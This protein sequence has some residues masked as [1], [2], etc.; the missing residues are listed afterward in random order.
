MKLLMLLSA[1]CILA[2]SYSQNFPA[3]EKVLSKEL[4]KESHKDGRWVFFPEQA[5]IQKLNAPLFKTIFPNYDLFQLV[6]TNYLGYHVNEGVCS[7]LFDSLTSQIILVEPIWYGGISEPL[8]KLFIGKK[9]ANKDSLLAGL[10]AMHQVLQIGSGYK[11][12][13]TSVSDSLVTYDLGYFKGDAYT[14]G[15]NGASTTIRYNEDGVWR[16]IRIEIDR[17]KI[18]RYTSINPKINE[19]EIIE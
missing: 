7:V 12:R 9:F 6:L 11:F 13:N 17:L 10:Y 5:N 16:K 4:S 8:V 15:G 14:T 1:F 19:S 18:I 3:L 2:D